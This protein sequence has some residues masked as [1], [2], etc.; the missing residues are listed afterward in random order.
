MSHKKIFGNWSKSLLL[1]LSVLLVLNYNARARTS[2]RLKVTMPHGGVLVGRYL[3]SFTG[4]GIL[5]FLGVPYAKP[6]VG[7]LRFKD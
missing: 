6:P 4:R 5:A 1:L 2:D 3:H 7:D